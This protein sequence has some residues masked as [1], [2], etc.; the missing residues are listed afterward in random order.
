MRLLKGL[1]GVALHAAALMYAGA[2]R[3]MRIGMEYAVAGMAGF[4]AD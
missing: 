4:D 2:G 3:N 1:P